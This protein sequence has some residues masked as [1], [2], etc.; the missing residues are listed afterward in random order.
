ML[1]W[2]HLCLIDRI[3]KDCPESSLFPECPQCMHALSIA[4]NECIFSSLPLVFKQARRDPR[5]LD[6]T[7]VAPW[8]R[9]EWAAPGGLHY[10][11]PGC[12]VWNNPP[13]ERSFNIIICS[14]KWD[15]G[16]E[17]SS[18][19]SKNFQSTNVQY[20]YYLLMNVFDAIFVQF[21]CI[22]EC[23]HLKRES[24]ALWLIDQH[25]SLITNK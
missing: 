4:G 24:S 25:R 23:S 21:P 5:G 1:A 7:H 9:T 12:R 2:C 15:H 3:S 11:H 18:L 16:Y 14:V 19:K 6:C 20:W 13:L 17:G 8:G 10:P 22:Y